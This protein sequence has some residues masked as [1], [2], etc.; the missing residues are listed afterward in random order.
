MRARGQ[1]VGVGSGSGG[2][3]KLTLPYP[4]ALSRSRA[5]V[6]QIRSSVRL[7]DESTFVNLLFPASYPVDNATPIGAAENAHE[8]TTKSLA[9]FL[10][11]NTYLFVGGDTNNCCIVGFHSFDFEPGVPQ[12]HDLPRAYVTDYASW[13]SPGLFGPSF[14][15]VTALSH[16]L[17]ET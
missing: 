17:A 16:E 3:G 10:F 14:Q 4:A 11:P 1:G 5:P 7:I 9:S 13:V 8:M 15:D 2:R 6:L 12:S